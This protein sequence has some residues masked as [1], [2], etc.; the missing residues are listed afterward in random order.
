M[1]LEI[2]LP[3]DEAKTGQLFSLGEYEAPRRWYMRRRSGGAAVVAGVLLP[4]RVLLNV[5]EGGNWKPLQLDD[6]G[7][8]LS[9]AA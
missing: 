3:A 8:L 6:H 5:L 4:L 7:P 9:W 2:S 1:L